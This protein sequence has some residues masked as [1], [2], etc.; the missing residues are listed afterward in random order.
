MKNIFNF[1]FTRIFCFVLAVLMMFTFCAC[2][3][4]PDSDVTSSD[5]T[6]TASGADVDSDDS[7]ADEESQVSSENTESAVSSQDTTSSKPSQSSSSTT[8]SSATQLPTATNPEGEQILGSG[9]KADPYLELPNVS[10]DY[11]SVTTVSIPA[12]KSVFYGIQRVVGTILTIENANAY[13]VFNSTRYDAKNGKVSFEVA[14]AKALASDNILF[15]IGNKGTSA[16][17]F[18]LIFTNKTGSR[19]NPTV[20]KTAGANTTINLEADNGTGHYY[21]YVAEKAGKLR[22]YMS[23]TVD[24]VVSVTNNTTSKNIIGNFTKSTGKLTDPDNGDAVVEYIEFDVAKGD[25]IIINVGAVPNKRGK[26]PAA[27][28]TWSA[29]FA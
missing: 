21:K 5:V 25:E 11:M 16:V 23:S 17:S 12:G 13:V 4:N 7:S 27:T 18:K 8:T 2:K 26:Y 20:V 29:K 19:E 15:E 22:F 6:Y 24:G 10:D 3:K 28:I 14:D 1:K 9:T